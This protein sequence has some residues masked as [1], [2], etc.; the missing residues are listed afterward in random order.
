MP[1]W[2]PAAQVMLVNDVENDRHTPE[3]W[4]GLVWWQ[5]FVAA[6]YWAI[7]LL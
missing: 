7:Q 1:R 5:G 6:G 4:L 2:A 3:P